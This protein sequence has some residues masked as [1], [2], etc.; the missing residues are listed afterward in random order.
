MD[1]LLAS[2][3]NSF[4][5]Y[6]NDINIERVFLFGAGFS[7]D[8]GFTTADSII[9]GVVEFY[10]R[11]LRINIRRLN[12][13]YDSPWHSW[14][15]HRLQDFFII[16]KIDH[17]DLN[18][19][20]FLKITSDPEYTEIRRHFFCLMTDYLFSYLLWNQ[21]INDKYI[22]FI[23]TIQ[24]TDAIL[25]FNWDV[26]PEALMRTQNIGFTRHEWT[27][28]KIM[29]IKLHGS[30]DLLSNPSDPMLRDLNELP[31]RFELL[32]YDLWRAVTAEEYW[33]WPVF[34][35]FKKLFPWMKYDK[36]GLFIVPPF[37]TSGYDFDY[38]K[39]NWARAEKILQN[40][41][42]IIAIGYSF[43][44]EDIKLLQ[45]LK[46]TFNKPTK[47]IELWNPDGNVRRKLK[48]F[49]ENIEITGE[50]IKFS[51]TPYISTE[52]NNDK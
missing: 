24:L 13:V 44:D 34:A 38:I 47:I 33:P 12:N 26:I 50:N 49:L 30:L 43:P 14:H 35:L 18:L 23:K 22:R 16:N 20:S 46:E 52:M 39:Y 9:S 7:R 29:I 21:V 48:N 5:K 8:F 51:D 17:H 2:Y 6:K 27:S 32:N 4:E 25:T 31:D 36:Q 11:D 41:K 10:E 3:Q 37:E 15:L 42:K 1:Y 40:C 45:L 19:Y 28:D